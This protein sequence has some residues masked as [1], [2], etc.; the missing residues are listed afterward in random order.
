MTTTFLH[1]VFNILIKYNEKIQKNSITKK[2][3][4]SNKMTFII[5]SNTITYLFKI[6]CL[7]VQT[8]VFSFTV[9]FICVISCGCQL[10]T[11]EHM[12]MMTMS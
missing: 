6:H 4:Q 8:Y 3:W 7:Y 2:V 5:F 10:H 12:M 11:K 1:L 9:V